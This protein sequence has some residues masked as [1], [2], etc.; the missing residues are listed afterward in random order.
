MDKENLP[1]ADI[2]YYTKQAVLDRERYDT[3]VHKQITKW[4]DDLVLN[5]CSSGILNK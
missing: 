5:G 2:Y 3:D 1:S 4:F